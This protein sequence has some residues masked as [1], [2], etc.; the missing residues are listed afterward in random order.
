ML[1]CDKTIEIFIEVDNFCEEFERKPLNTY[2][3][4]S[5][6]RPRPG[7]KTIQPLARRA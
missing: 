1:T 5:I 2:L 3:I 6:R 4:T 7:T